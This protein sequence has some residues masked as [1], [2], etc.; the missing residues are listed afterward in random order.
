[1]SGVI[2]KSGRSEVPFVQFP[3]AI[4]QDSKIKANAKVV[5]LYLLSLPPGFEVKRANLHDSFPEG[6][7]WIR[8]GFDALIKLG[9]ITKSSVLDKGKF[10][11]VDYEVHHQPVSPQPE[12]PAPVIP[13]ADTPAPVIQ[14]SLIRDKEIR[15]KIIKNNDDEKQKSSPTSGKEVK[16]S[17]T[18]PEAE[19]EQVK[20]TP[21]S[22]APLPD[23]SPEWLKRQQEQQRETMKPGGIK[24][25][26]EAVQEIKKAQNLDLIISR[27]LK[28]FKASGWTL[29]TV[30]AKFI[31]QKS[32]ASEKPEWKSPTD[33]RK[34]FLAW[35]PLHF[36]NPV[37]QKP[38][39]YATQSREPNPGY[40]DNIR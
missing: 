22:A 27:T 32:F 3:R 36:Q 6:R 34:N 39:S 23:E 18:T 10:A 19:I 29:D 35:L 13:E 5:L 31:E 8:D 9:Y 25:W 38:V 20:P 16:S 24:T 30:I 15:D 21:S 28:T 37:N 33:L 26:E 14:D 40:F 2:R 12:I 4:A 7:D 1:M 11:G 17:S